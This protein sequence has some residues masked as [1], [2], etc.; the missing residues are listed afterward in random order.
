MTETASH[1]F[2]SEPVEVVASHYFVCD[3]GARYWV[4]ELADGYVIAEAHRA[5]YVSTATDLQITGGVRKQPGTGGLIG[6]RA[7][8]TLDTCHA[9][10]GGAAVYG[11]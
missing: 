4:R 8:L 11:L 1:P 3:G 9:L 2:A 6:R 5:T 10:P 7:R